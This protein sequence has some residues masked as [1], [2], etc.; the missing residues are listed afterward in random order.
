MNLLQALLAGTSAQGIPR[1]IQSIDPNTGEPVSGPIL[2]GEMPRP[3]PEIAMPQFQGNF[4]QMT[5]GA[6]PVAS[7]SPEILQA[8]GGSPATP[9]VEMPA[10]QS[11]QRPRRSLLDTLGQIS[12]V[13]ARVG[14]AEPLYQP[15]LDARED[16]QRAI[17][18]E[19]LRRQQL[20]QQMQLGG[21]QIRAGEEGFADNARNRLAM[22][23]GALAGD[24][25]AAKKWPQIAAQAG[26]DENQADWAG[27]LI[28]QGYAPEQIAASLGWSPNVGKGQG[29]L[30]KEVQL[31]Q[32]LMQE[33]GPEMANAYLQSLVNPSSMTPKQQADVQA[34]LA[35]LRLDREKFDYQRERDANPPESVSERR[36]REKLIQSLPKVEAA[37]RSF[38]KDIDKQIREL[39]QLRE[40][41]GLGGITGG[42]LGRLPSVSGASTGAQAILNTINAR[43]GFNTLQE[44][45]N[46]SPTGGALGSVSEAEGKRLIDAAASLDQTQSKA[47]FQ[48]SIDKYISDLEFSKN[49]IA[50]T[51]KDTYA[52][53][54]RTSSPRPTSPRTGSGQRTGS[55]NRPSAPTPAAPPPPSG[56]VTSKMI[57]AALRRKGLM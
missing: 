26:I 20:E 7:P 9:A 39:K 12:D 1:P 46:N 53:I 48:K 14:G 43:A 22:A 23:L 16:R 32:M 56:P 52:N 47:D 5:Q 33:G 41:P 34:S 15:T 18:L 19:E 21:Q 30:A 28:R 24:P 11:S 31:Y 40:H 54:Q 50:Q 42:I 4:Q 2:N 55:S 36:D 44:M 49:N 37:Y 27:Q 51:F 3:A 45:R 35:R 10:Q 13:L 29:S 25:D 8:I 17:D 6:P 38:T 57:E